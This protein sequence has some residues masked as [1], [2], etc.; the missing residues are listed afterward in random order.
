MAIKIGLDA[1]CA[2]IKLAYYDEN[3]AIV[4]T[5]VPA[6]A[7]LGKSTVGIHANTGVTYQCAGEEWSINPDLTNTED[8]RF[9]SYPYSILN[10][11]LSVHSL[12]EAGFTSSDSVQVASGIPLN[13]FYDDDL[14]NQDNIDRK[15]TIFKNKITVRGGADLPAPVLSHVFPEALAGWVDI[16]FNDQG[17][18]TEQQTRPV[19]LVDIGGRT[20]DIAVCL[21][22][23]QIDPDYTGTIDKGY[24]DVCSKLNEFLIRDFDSGPLNT[25]VLDESLR[26]QTIQLYRG[27]SAQDISEQ[28]SAAIGFVSGEIL[29]EAERKLK[30]GHLAGICYFG[31][32]AEHMREQLSKKKNVYIPERPQFSNARGYLK[33]MT[34]LLG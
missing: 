17:E 2:Y 18:D 13:H 11:V 30:G 12:S 23:F 22:G 34:F 1:G 9:P 10:Q 8:T 33:T 4:E 24:L 3:G 28:V 31:G 15:M 26:T 29:R 25:A 6:L 32:G 27:Q 19:G 20:T 5:S 7:K 14:I 21:P 16:S